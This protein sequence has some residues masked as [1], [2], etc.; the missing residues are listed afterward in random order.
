MIHLPGLQ[1][2][3][4][5]LSWAIFDDSRTH[6]LLLGRQWAD[7]SLWPTMVTVGL[8]PSD[9]DHLKDDQTIRKEIGFAKRYGCGGLIKANLLTIIETESRKLKDLR[10]EQSLHPSWEAA[11][12][13]ALVPH[14]VGSIY[15]A[16]WGQLSNHVWHLSRSS[17]GAA[18]HLAEAP[19]LYCFGRCKKTSRHARSE[20]RHTSR[21]AYSTPLVSLATGE[22]H[23]TKPKAMGKA[24]S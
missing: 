17:R 7:A 20:P 5:S 13:A 1:T 15:V 8:N 24:I 4:G 16:A 3:G 11:L 10:L 19:H 18:H 2:E 23:P 12:R 9:A 6:R 22:L 21:I 14:G